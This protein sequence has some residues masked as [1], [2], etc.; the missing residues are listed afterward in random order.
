VNIADEDGAIGSVL[1]FESL[2]ADIDRR[3]AV[4][5]LECGDR[6][7]L[8]LLSDRRRGRNC[9]DR[10]RTCG[11]ACKEDA[12]KAHAHHLTAPCTIF[13]RAP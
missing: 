5:A 7:L 9:A 6:L 13:K 12:R 11:E 8:A 4:M 1:H 10:D 3:I 2:R